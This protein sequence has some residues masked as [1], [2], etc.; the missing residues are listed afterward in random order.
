MDKA[1]KKKRSWVRWLLCIALLVVVVVISSLHFLDNRPVIVY[2]GVEKLEVAV[3][4]LENEEKFDYVISRLMETNYEYNHWYAA[5]TKRTKDVV[6]ST[7]QFETYISADAL[8]L[9]VDDELFEYLRTI[10]TDGRLGRISIRKYPAAG[11]YP[12][13]FDVSFGFSTPITQGAIYYYYSTERSP[14]AEKKTNII[15]NWY[16]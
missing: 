6:F 16:M 12:M 14:D 15:G 11:N 7:D 1:E 9:A 3:F 13:I 2:R 10:L 4:F 5:I 8:G